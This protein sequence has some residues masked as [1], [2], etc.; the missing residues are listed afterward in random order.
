MEQIHEEGDEYQ[1]E[2]ES[3]ELSSESSECINDFSSFIEEHEYPL[4]Y[5]TTMEFGFFDVLVS[6]KVFTHEQVSTIKEND[7]YAN[8]LRQLF[9]EI[10][11]R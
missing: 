6:N 1:E 5:M 4:V 2:G 11:F 7:S 8:Q 9:N 10:T 3:Q